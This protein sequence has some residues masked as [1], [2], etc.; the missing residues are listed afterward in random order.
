LGEK[1]KPMIFFYGVST[2]IA[3][4]IGLFAIV[5]LITGDMPVTRSI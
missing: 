2:G 3:F 1:E 5:N 4:M